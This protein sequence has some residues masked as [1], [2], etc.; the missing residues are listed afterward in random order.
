M[1]NSRVF[2]VMVRTGGE[3]VARAILPVYAG[4]GLVCAVLFG[5]TGLTPDTFVAIEAGDPI[6]R[7]V[8]WAMWLSATVGAARIGLLGRE[9]IYFRALP[10][11]RWQHLGLAMALVLALETPWIAVFGLGGGWLEAA[12]AGTLAAAIAA[13]VAVGPRGWIGA[14]AR[15]ACLAA[16]G[17]AIWQP[18]AAHLAAPLGAVVFAVAAALA[19]KRAP[20]RNARALRL[21]RGGAMVA[22]MASGVAYVV[23]RRRANFERA[24][25]L[26]AFGAAGAWLLA[27]SNDIDA[28]ASLS[29]LALGVGALVLAIAAG[30]LAVALVEHERSARWLL[31]STGTPLFLRAIASAVPLALLMALLGAGIGVGA[32]LGSEGPGARAIVTSIVAGVGWAQLALVVVRRCERRDGVDATRALAWLFLLAVL[33]IAAVISLDDAAVLG[34]AALGAGAGLVGTRRLEAPSQRWSSRS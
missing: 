32:S 14:V 15:A 33:M 18:L 6:G 4:L 34:L 25:L 31:D 10:I 22:V 3:P 8:L 17:V 30:A 29:A 1:Q 7:L 26:A 12:R 20:E 11:A 23:R 9:L 13:V 28:A 16:L 24:V 2:L 21:V 27:R 19:W 5:P